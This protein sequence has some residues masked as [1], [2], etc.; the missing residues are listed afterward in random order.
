M[1]FDSPDLR[2]CSVAYQKLKGCTPLVVTRSLIVKQD[3]SWLLHV[4]GHLV[5]PSKF[6]TLAAIPTSLNHESAMRLLSHIVELNTCVGNPEG[7]FISLGEAKKN[8][9]FLS[10][11][12]EVVA[13]VDSTACVVIGE[14]QYARTIRCSKCHFLT[15]EVRC[16]ECAA[17]RK[18]LLSQHS[19]ETRRS[20]S[21]PSKTT[22]FRYCV[23]NKC[24][25]LTCTILFTYF[26]KLLKLRFLTHYSIPLFF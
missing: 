26:S 2:L 12:K 5:D 14:Q 25:T 10:Q 23:Y 7:K 24:S 22:N 20:H 6:T 1:S 8:G 11:E 21:A 4:H 3:Y 9:N 13:Y 18:N 15:S 19:R 17:Y 16:L